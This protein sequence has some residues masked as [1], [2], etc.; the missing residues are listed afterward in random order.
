MYIYIFFFRFFSIVGYC[1]LLNIVL[2]AT[3]WA[4]QVVL[5]VKN[6]PANAGNI[7]DTDLIPGFGRLPLKKAWSTHFSLLA[8][9]ISWTEDPGGPWSVGLQRVLQD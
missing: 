6:P 5:M 1:T 9:R 2:C 4:S 3:Q 8:Q 7:R